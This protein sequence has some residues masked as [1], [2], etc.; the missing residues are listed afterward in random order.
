[1]FGKSALFACLFV[2]QGEAF[3]LACDQANSWE[4][5]FSQPMLFQRGYRLCESTT[6][7][8]RVLAEVMVYLN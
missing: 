4:W 6:E 7:V 3:G 1:M 5:P 2:S 8:E